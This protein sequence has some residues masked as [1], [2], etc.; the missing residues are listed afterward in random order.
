MDW[1]ASF[2]TL[3]YVVGFPSAL[4]DASDAVISDSDA[5]QTTG[6]ITTLTAELRAKVRSVVVR[7]RGAMIH[8]KMDLEAGDNVWYEGIN[9][10]LMPADGW[11]LHVDSDLLWMDGGPL[12]FGVRHTLDYVFYPSLPGVDSSL[13]GQK[14]PNHRFGLLAAYRFRDAP[15]AAFDRPTVA[16]IVNWHLKHPYR[17]GQEINQAMPYILVAFAFRGDLF[18]SND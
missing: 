8:S 13:V 1:M 9:D 6:R 16:V 12:I 4:E 18:S 3:G 10:V 2:G 17:A 7:S 14:T 5:I 11:M 15:G